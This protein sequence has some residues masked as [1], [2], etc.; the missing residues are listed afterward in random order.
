MAITKEYE[1]EA[2]TQGEYCVSVKT[3]TIIKE[4]GVEISQTNGRTPITPF[5]DYSM[6]PSKI[7]TI[8]DAVFTDE[9][10]AK[11]AEVFE[12]INFPTMQEQREDPDNP[13]F[14]IAKQYPRGYTPPE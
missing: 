14:G 6:F 7:K 4:D 9:L 8:C 3:I 1:Y 12:S 2:N 5:D 13:N 10:K 11:Y